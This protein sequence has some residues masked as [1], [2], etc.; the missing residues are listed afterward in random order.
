MPETDPISEKTMTE[1]I[2]GSH[3]EYQPA[4]IATERSAYM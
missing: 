1:L 2:Y 4:M 3:E